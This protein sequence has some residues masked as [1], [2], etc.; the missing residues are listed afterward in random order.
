VYVA[1]Q[2]VLQRKRTGSGASQVIEQATKEIKKWLR[3]EGYERSAKDRK[4]HL[5][6][7]TASTVVD[8]P[9]DGECKS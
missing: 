4:M 2:I 8:V 9:G 3:E 7:F 1:H 5:S 6:L